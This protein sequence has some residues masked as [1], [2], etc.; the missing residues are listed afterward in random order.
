MS[1]IAIV[2]CPHCGGAVEI[3]ELSCGI[4]RHGVMIATSLQM[5]AHASE[6]ICNNLI[7]QNLIYGCG[8]PFRIESN[9][10]IVCDYL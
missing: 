8:K 6:E 3:I 7:E 1:D 2:F 10:A 4:F 9:V 5:D